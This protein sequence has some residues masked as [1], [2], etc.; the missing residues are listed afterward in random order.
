[1]RIALIGVPFDLDQHER[2]MGL[3]PGALRAAG[4]TDRL[5]VAGVEVVRDL[6]LSDNLAPGNT[7]A[8]LG[9]LQA[10][11]AGEV[12]AACR[13]GLIPV[14]LGGDCCNAIGMWSGLT[15]ARPD[16]TLGVAWFD[17]HGDWNTEETTLSGYLGGMPY[18]AICGYGNLDLRY[19]AGL[20]TP[21][22]PDRCA[23]LGV[24]DLDPPEAELLATTPVTVLDTETLRRSAPHPI[25]SGVDAL[26]LHVDVDV[27]DTRVA[28][29]VA[30]PTD[31]GLTL[32]D[33]VGLVRRLGPP[34]A[35]VSLTAVDPLRDP[36]GIT[37]KTGI[38]LLA[39]ILAALADQHEQERTKSRGGRPITQR[40]G[41]N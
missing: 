28:P 36:E 26:Y 1:M 37:V 33:L 41:Y 7:H 25:L 3:A 31:G 34:V 17:A 14:L 32:D 30:Y 23:L 6:T 9:Q 35:A 4:L 38:E 12:A 11:V 13:D 27:L 18:A 20:L 22:V 24:R 40:F 21:A 29:G 19:A 15:R 2:G 10:E 5:A 8:R 39:A 16:A